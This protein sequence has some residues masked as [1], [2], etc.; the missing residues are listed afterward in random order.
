MTFDAF[1]H[2]L[3]DSDPDETAEWMESLDTLVATEGVS[4]ARYV[5]G[6]LAERARSLQVGVP[7]LV[8]TPY[9]NT[10]PP[11]EEPWFPGDEEMERRIRRIVRW[12]AAVMVTRANKRTDGIGGHLSTYA[13]SAS[14]YEVGFNHFFRGKDDGRSGDQIYYQG[15]A[16][17][18]MYS[19][20]FLEGRLTEEHLDNFRH[21]AGGKGLS[22]YPHPRLMPEFWEFPTVSMGLGP[23]NAIYQARFNRYLYQRK[24]ADT[25]ESRVWAFLGDG[26][27]DEPEATGALSLAAREQLDNLVFVIS[28][29]LQRLDGPVRGN[30]KIIQELESLFR[31]AGWNVVKVIWAREWDP[32]LARDVDGVLVDKMNSTNDGQFQKYS[33]ESGAYIRESFFGP[34]PRLRRLVEH[35]GD[36]DLR[37]LRRGGHDYRKLYSAYRLALEQK[38]APTVILAHTV[39]GWTLGSLFEGRNATHQ[40]KKI[41]DTELK[42][43]RDKLQLPIS[44]KQLDDGI[45]PY[46]HPGSRS[47]EIDYLMSRRLALGGTLPKRVVRSRPLT[48]PGD[49]VWSDSIGG[50]GG[51]PASTTAAFGAILRNLLR[52]PEVGRRVVPIIPDEARTFGMDALFREVKIYSPFGQ[53]YEPVDANM[54]LSYQEAPDGQL[55]EEGITEAGAMGSFSAAGTAYATHGEPMIPFYIYYSMFGYQRV[56]DLVW[57]FGD[58]RGRGFMLGGTAGRTTLNGEGLQHQDGHS[59]LLFSA[60]P[61]CEVY[62]PAYAFEVAV[63]IREGMRRMYERGEDVFYYLTLYNENYPM[64]AMPEGTEDGILRGLYRL[65]RAPE[66]RAHRLQLFASGT[67][68]QAA[69]EAQAMLAE[70][71]V[72]ADVWSVTSYLALRNDALSVERWNRLHPDGPQRTSHLLEQLRDTEGPVVAV[73][74]YQKTVAEQVARFVPQRFVPLGTDGYGRS[75]TRAAL[76]SHFEVDAP[77]ITVAALDALADDDRVPRHVVTAALE[78]YEIRTEGAEPRL[79]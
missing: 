57:A 70:H 37:H 64:P 21:E 75:D 71:D 43:F 11:E 26:E 42:A 45:A 32:L 50:S 54:V 56:G 72:A 58:A 49:K 52:D 17:P 76:R 31:G 53:R 12:N 20:A 10:I 1:L 65:Q 68:M 55:L 19:R 63:I 69:L 23:L 73:T 61:N 8:S 22:S 46:Y 60:V 33:T 9:I 34:D 30:G 13:S 59:P 3:P 40:I 62:D 44:D 77:H 29:N 14:L 18:G 2:Q 67:A 78:Q 35:L 25:S 15:H 74:D 79:L 27:M 66:E 4:R 41:G 16:A 51:R 48:I 28:C 5:I 7:A 39:K 6:K 47:E 38:G 24:I 36:D